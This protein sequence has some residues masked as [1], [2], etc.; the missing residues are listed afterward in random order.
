MEEALAEGFEAFS[1]ADLAFHLS[2]AAAT[3]N[4][5]LQACDEVILGL[6]RSMVR[7]KLAEAPDTLAQ[8]KDS[9]GRHQMVFDA[10]ETGDAAKAAYLARVHQVEYYGDYLPAEV[11][12]R[13]ELLYQASS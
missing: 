5:L 12:L 8:M 1:E 10:I 11:R 3:D 9:L 6:V 4:P 7:D 2:V 13:L